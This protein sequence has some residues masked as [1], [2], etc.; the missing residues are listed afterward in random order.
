MF[1]LADAALLKIKLVLL[2]IIVAGIVTLLWSNHVYKQQID[3]LKLT[4]AAN[5]E[6][7]KNISTSLDQMTKSGEITKAALE[8]IAS[9]VKNSNTKHEAIANATAKS[10]KDINLKYSTLPKDENNTVK[11]LTEISTVK[12]RGLWSSYCAND[13]SGPDCI[14]AAQEGV[15]P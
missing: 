3:T 13:A 10:V 14:K 15:V 2:G 8:K 6:T 1:G 9:D 5:N 7:L 11:R 12:I 4:V